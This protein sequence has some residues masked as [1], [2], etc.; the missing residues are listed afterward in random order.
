MNKNIFTSTAIFVLFAMAFVS[1]HFLDYE[2]NLNEPI[3]VNLQANITPATVSR[4]INDQWQAGDQVGL[5][6]VRT[7]HWL[8]AENVLNDVF[9]TRMTVEG[10]MLTSHQPIMYPMAENVDFIA[11]YPFTYQ[12]NWDGWSSPSIFVVVGDQSTGLVTEML[13]SNNI[14]NQVPTPNAVTLDFR[15]SLAKLEITVTGGANSVLTATDFANMTVSIDGLPTQANF[16]LADGTF[17]NHCG[18]WQTV[19]AHRISSSS[20]SATFRVLVLPVNNEITFNFNVGGV[21]HPHPVWV[22]YQAATLYQLNFRLDFPAVALTN[23]RIIPRVVNSEHFTVNM[24]W[25][26]PSNVIDEGVVINGIRWATRNVDAPGTFA[27]NPEDAGM[28][29]RWNSRIGWSTTDPLVSHLGDTDMNMTFFPAPIIGN[30]WEV[31]N[32]PCPPGWRVPTMYELQLLWGSDWWGHQGGE[33]ATRNGVVGWYLGTYPNRIFLPAAGF[34]AGTQLFNENCDVRLAGSRVVSNSWDSFGGNMG[35]FS[36]NCPSGNTFNSEFSGNEAFS[37]RCVED[38]H[39]HSITL[40]TTAFVLPADGAKVLTATVEPTHVGEEIFWHSNNTAVV[41]IDRL[42]LTHSDKSAVAAAIAPGTA[43]ITATTR[44]GNKIAS[45]TV[46]V[47]NRNVSSVEINGIRWA[48]RNVGMPGTFVNSPEDIGRFYQ[49]NNRQS[50]TEPYWGWTDTALT[51]D[52]WEREHDPCPEG[53]RVPTIAELE[54]LAGSHLASSILGFGRRNGVPGS[55]F[56]YGTNLIFLPAETWGGSYWGSTLHQWGW[57]TP[58]TPAI[59]EI[60]WLGEGFGARIENSHAYAR[61][62]VRCVVE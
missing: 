34:R 53:W 4:V 5:F 10:G 20:N 37:V 60:G 33:W 58:L 32:D 9:N 39:A 19:G 31:A 12:L 40:N 28:F 29:Y 1:C 44:Y 52:I 21:T 2:Y 56:G 14:T 11:Y 13:Y 27:A 36:W 15:Y 55:F 47:E 51:S 59:L 24:P 46:T 3:A 26:P 61:N 17:S 8:S 49:W 38:V 18:W 7:G 48:T 57:W 45:A 35:T 54:S 43:T 25:I 6:M 23:T 41:T 16:E 30:V 42:F 22:N 62:P 50:W